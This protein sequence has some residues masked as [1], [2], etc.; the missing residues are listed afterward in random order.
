M[1]IPAPNNWILTFEAKPRTTE[2]ASKIKQVLAKFGK[3]T[4]SPI[5][6]IPRSS[7]VGP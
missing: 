5:T 2:G 7:E 4:F 6:T 1:K 3:K